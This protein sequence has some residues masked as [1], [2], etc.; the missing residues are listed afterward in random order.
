MQSITFKVKPDSELYKNYFISKK[1]RI[2]FKKLAIS[3]IEMHIPEATSIDCNERLTVALSVTDKEK[4]ANQL[5][6]SVKR[7]N[8][9]ILHQF[10]K[11]SVL[12]HLWEKQVCSRVDWDAIDINNLWFLNFCKDWFKISYSLWDDDKGN[13]YG[14]VE[15]MDDS[16]K[17]IVPDDVELIHRS[18]RLRRH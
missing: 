6:K 5:T 12:N 9:K 11:N 2:F 7:Y 1:E 3:F 15:T 14:T 13:V 10:R 8:G 16:T 17:L 4:Y 18:R